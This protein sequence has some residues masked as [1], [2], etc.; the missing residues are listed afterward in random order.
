MLF[1]VFRYIFDKLHGS[2]L[3]T[4]NCCLRIKFV[5]FNLSENK[6][7]V[8]RLTLVFL[9]QS[10]LKA[11]LA[12][13]ILLFYNMSNCTCQIVFTLWLYADSL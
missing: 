12:Q 10:L 1:E 11:L 7:V 9:F 5:I 6:V 3:Q 13:I 2:Y 8:H 4:F